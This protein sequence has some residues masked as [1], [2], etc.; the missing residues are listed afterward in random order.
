VYYIAVAFVGAL[1]ISAGY[2]FSNV[3]SV[4]A[5][6]NLIWID[7][8]ALAPDQLNLAFGSDIYPIYTDGGIFLH[9]VNLG[10]E[11]RW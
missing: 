8:V 1:N 5:G 2:R 9:G 6:Y 11:G 3:W 10:L 7:R 4:R